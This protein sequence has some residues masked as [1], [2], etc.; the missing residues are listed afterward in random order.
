MLR[1]AAAGNDGARTFADM[2]LVAGAGDQPRQAA[3]RD[4]LAWQRLVL[5]SEGTRRQ[6]R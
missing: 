1:A 3:P 5:R 6:R 2:T 4:R